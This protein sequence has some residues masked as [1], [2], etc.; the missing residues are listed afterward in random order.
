MSSEESDSTLKVKVGDLIPAFSVSTL[1]KDS[2]DWRAETLQPETKDYVFSEPKSQKA[3]IVFFNTECTDCQKEL[4]VLQDFYNKYKND[5]SFEMIC[6][7]RAQQQ[8]AIE[9]YWKEHSLT[10]PFSPQ[11]DR[12]VYSMFANSGIPLIVMTNQKGN[13]TYIYTDKNTPTLSQLEES[14]K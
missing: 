1:I 10:L 2:A 4:P 14:I 6:I 9:T 7:A 3:C 11:G 13:I 8:E 12:A 5:R